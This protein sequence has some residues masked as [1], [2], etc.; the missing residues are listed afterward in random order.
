MKKLSILLLCLVLVGCQD[1]INFNEDL[2]LG[3]M[4][5][6]IPLYYG[7]FRAVQ[8]LSTISLYLGDRIYYE[9]TNG[10]QTPAQI[11]RRRRADCDGYALCWM[12]IAYI[13][14]G[15]KTDLCIVKAEGS[16]RVESGGTDYNH[17][18]VRLPDGRQMDAQSGRIVKY[19][20]KYSYS[21]DDVFVY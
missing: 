4:F 20:V 9:P 7:D 21:F 3:D 15:I 10:V 16:R 19:T 1:I 13:R 18:V 11:F 14:F 5:S 6:G 8:S 12:N 17:A 2:L